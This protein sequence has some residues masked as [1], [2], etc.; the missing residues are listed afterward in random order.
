M[1]TM[2]YIIDLFLTL[3]L[4]FWSMNALNIGYEREDNGNIGL[5]LQPGEFSFNDGIHYFKTD[6]INKIL[7]EEKRVCD[8]SSIGHSEY[9][10][11]IHFYTMHDR[12]FSKRIN[13]QTE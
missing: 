10:S 13:K 8:K 11:K 1:K 6:G 9:S 3:S 7:D 12:V 5:N 2:V 4:F